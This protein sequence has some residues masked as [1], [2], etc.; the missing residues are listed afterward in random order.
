M[1]RDWFVEKFLEYKKDNQCKTHH[2]ITNYTC[3]ECGVSVAFTY[4]WQEA[5]TENWGG[6]NE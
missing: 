3:H 4:I 6:I 1:D 2:P 5:V